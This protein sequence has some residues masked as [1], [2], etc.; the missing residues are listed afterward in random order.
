M[1]VRRGLGAPPTQPGTV[2][3]RAVNASPALSQPATGR[4]LDPT[5]DDP[6]ESYPMSAQETK[7]RRSRPGL[8]RALAATAMIALIV[9]V[10]LLT[11]VVQR[12]VARPIA[13]VYAGATHT[14]LTR[15]EQQIGHRVGCVLEYSSGATTWAQWVDPWFISNASENSNWSGFARSGHQM[16]L[17]INLF[18]TDVAGADWR[19]AGAS[20]A[21]AAHAH[22]LARNL[23]RAGMG[24]AVI[25]LASEANGITYTDNVGKTRTQQTEWKQFWRRT[26]LAMRSVPGAHFDFNWCIAN[27]P[28]AIPF[29]HYYP[30]NDVVDSVGDDVYDSGLPNNVGFDDRWQYVYGEPGGVRTIAAFARAH[31]KPL[32]IP[33]WGLAP[34][35]NDGGGSDPAFTRGFLRFLRDDH[36]QSE[37]YFFSSSFSST[38]LGDPASLALYRSQIL[39]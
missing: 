21:Y 5:S 26:A 9:G 4:S 27:G 36:V 13:C 29:S 24:H 34:S 15:F 17:T 35:S 25:R 20:G 18:P 33:E 6:H 30:G 39:G 12:G 8:G 38:L 23:V 32:T 19:A 11:G 28:R 7:P 10:G 2:R 31:H 3:L 14:D 1:R 16:I 22:K 37:A